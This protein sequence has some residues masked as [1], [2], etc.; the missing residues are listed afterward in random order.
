LVYLAKNDSNLLLEKI[1]IFSKAKVDFEIATLSN[2][3]TLD[4]NCEIQSLLDFYT[5]LQNRMENGEYFLR[6]GA[7]KTFF[8]NVLVLALLNYKGIGEEQLREVYLHYGTIFGL[9]SR[10]PIT[11]TVTKIGSLPFGW[12][13]IEKI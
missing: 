7:S 2:A 11:R 5:D 4:F 9:Q 3:K 1:N 13:K 8:D 12:V 6:I 10:Y